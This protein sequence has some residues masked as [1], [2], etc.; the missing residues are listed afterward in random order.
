[1]ALQLS[2][3]DLSQQR[4]REIFGA[5]DAAYRNDP[6]DVE[7]F[8]EAILRHPGDISQWSLDAKR[9]AV[10]R[11]LGPGGKEEEEVQ[12]AL[13]LIAASCHGEAEL[14]EVFAGFNVGSGAYL[15]GRA[16]EWEAA[17]QTAISQGSWIEASWADRL[18]AAATKLVAVARMLDDP[19]VDAATKAALQAEFGT[20][21][22]VKESISRL[23]S[24]CDL[25]RSGTATIDS[26]EEADVIRRDTLSAENAFKN[27]V[28]T[29]G[30]R[31]QLI[32]SYA[33]EAFGLPA[34]N[35]APTPTA[36]IENPT[37][38]GAPGEGSAASR[39]GSPDQR[40]RD[41]E[42]R[43]LGRG[44][45][46]SEQLRNEI[47]S[48]SGQISYAETYE[49]IEAAIDDTGMIA[50]FRAGDPQ[51]MEDLAASETLMLALKDKLGRIGN[52]RETLLSLQDEEH[53]R[54][55]KIAESISR[56]A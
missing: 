4:G 56:I 19:A 13:L 35:A 22:Q 15:G 18:D 42:S 11:L 16:A 21:A 5:V 25:L 17:Q 33:R 24:E 44:N 6:D 14:K 26:Q 55:K 43:W 20:A 53:S 38:S 34:S 46:T 40:A 7:Y 28:D 27:A 30:W 45:A 51:L 36:E 10:R 52:L 9:E 37:V 31:P 2:T 1:M 50:A 47:L 12:N 3:N 32:P 54:R 8:A 41:A 29:L 39:P 23:R 49:L 48:R